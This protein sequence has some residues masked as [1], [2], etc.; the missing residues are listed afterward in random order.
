MSERVN[1]LNIG[2]R[3]ILVGT[4]H[5]DPASA[6]L[7]RETVRS[8]MP[9]VVALELDAD[10]L[11]ALQNP[12]ASRPGISSGLSFLFMALIEKFAGQLTGS[13]PGLEMVEAVK[14]ARTVGARV[15]LIDRPIRRTIEG[16]RKLPLREKLRLG[17]DGVASLVLLPFGAVDVSNLTEDIDSQLTVF[18]SRYPRLSQILL[19]EREQYMIN[20][21]KRILDGTSGKVVGVVGFGHL[22]AVSR[23][24]EGY[25]ERPGY[26]ASLNW[27]LGVG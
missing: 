24:L 9:E 22:S 25:T 11:R 3:L 12:E 20:R 15:E 14:A 1:T 21:I 18:R 17:A 23:A 16:I 13:S 4:V 6:S 7:V 19:D 10:R 5:V 26:S 8:T 2:S 27:T